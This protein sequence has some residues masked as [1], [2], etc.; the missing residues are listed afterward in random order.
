[1]KIAKM[2]G[3]GQKR[4][5]SGKPHKSRWKAN[6]GTFRGLFFSGAAEK[7]QNPDEWLHGKLPKIEKVREMHKNEE[8]V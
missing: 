7:Q 5:L 6:F 2:H 4:K 8:N 1:M 3:D